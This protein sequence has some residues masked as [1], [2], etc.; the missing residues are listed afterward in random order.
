MDNEHNELKKKRLFSGVERNQRE[1]QVARPSSRS[2]E[3]MDLPAGG[4]R[5][6]CP[7]GLWRCDQVLLAIQWHRVLEH[8]DRVLAVQRRGGAGAEAIECT[9]SRAGRRCDC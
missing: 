1:A 2:N 3:E 8:C 4:D 7:G 9:S 6:G 5:G